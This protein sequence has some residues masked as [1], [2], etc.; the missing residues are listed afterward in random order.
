MEQ[1]QYPIDPRCTK[2]GLHI[3][4]VE[5]LLVCDDHNDKMINDKVFIDLQ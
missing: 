5:D 4:E 3:W 1:C 2:E